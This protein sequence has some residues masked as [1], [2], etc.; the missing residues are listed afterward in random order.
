MNHSFLPGTAKKNG[1]EILAQ[2]TVW[3]QYLKDNEL[4]AFDRLKDGVHLNASGEFVMAEFMKAHLRYAPSLANP[5]GEAIGKPAKWNQGKLT[6]ELDGNQEQPAK[7]GRSSAK[8]NAVT[9][10]PR[11]DRIAAA[12]SRTLDQS[13]HRGYLGV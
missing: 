3:K 11:R 5:K 9:R 4:H 10:L 2:R 12:R 6:V 8:L 13:T 7:G 1:V